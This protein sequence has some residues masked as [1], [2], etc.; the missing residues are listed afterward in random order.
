MDNLDK[1]TNKKIKSALRKEVGSIYAI[2]IFILSSFIVYILTCILFK[3]IAFIPQKDILMFELSLLSNKW[4]VAILMYTLYIIVFF[5]ILKKKIVIKDSKDFIQKFIIVSLIF[6]CLTI[7][8]SLCMSKK[9]L[10]TQF[11]TLQCLYPVY[12]D[13][14]TADPTSDFYIKN[15]NTEF[16]GEFSTLE[17]VND[18]FLKK[19][20]DA[21]DY[22]IYDEV[23]LLLLGAAFEIAG[24]LICVK[25]VK[26]TDKKE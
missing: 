1:K 20:D 11:L 14:V 2:I 17:E 21:I 10:H 15:Y 19:Y 22:Y 18:G 13:L 8:M 25:L 12:C 24:M 3:L 9:K 26:Y 7:F 23:E 5:V 16:I 4:A 6:T